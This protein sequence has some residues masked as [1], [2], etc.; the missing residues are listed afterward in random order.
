MNT[1]VYVQLTS[2]L[3]KSNCYMYMHREFF[4]YLKLFIQKPSVYLSRADFDQHWQWTLVCFRIL[5]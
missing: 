1:Y 3:I 5:F 2:R 4:K